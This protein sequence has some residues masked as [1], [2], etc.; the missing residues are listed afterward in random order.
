M[1]AQK[2]STEADLLPS[3]DE[4]FDQELAENAAIEKFGAVNE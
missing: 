2:S 4:L 3:R 1:A